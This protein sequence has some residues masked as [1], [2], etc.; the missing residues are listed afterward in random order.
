MDGL[1]TLKS[2]LSREALDAYKQHLLGEIGDG[3]LT[4]KRAKIEK[5][6]VPFIKS[7]LGM[8][9]VLEQREFQAFFVNLL[10][11]VREPCKRMELAKKEAMVLFR[12][13]I[14]AFHPLSLKDCS[15]ETKSVHAKAWARFL[16]P[17]A[18]CLM[19]LYAM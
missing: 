5:E 2:L 12:L 9:S 10:E 4:S 15:P 19:L 18:E 6:F 3:K 11:K 17:L 16:G 7:L 13:L 1:K 8:I 14:A